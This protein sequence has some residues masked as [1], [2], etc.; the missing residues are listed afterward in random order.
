M[1]LEEL[2][3]YETETVRFKD[4]FDCATFSNIVIP[5]PALRRPQ[6]SS[7][8]RRFE[9]DKLSELKRRR[10]LGLLFKRSNQ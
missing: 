3:N 4:R 8:P 1:R 5:I 9:Y 2:V 7:H 6:P 10:M